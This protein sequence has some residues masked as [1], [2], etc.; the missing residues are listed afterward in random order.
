MANKVG[1]LIKEARTEAGYTQEQLAR[2][3]KD[4]SAADISKA[5]RGELKLS[6]EALK[7]IAKATGVTQK[8]LLDAASSSSYKST[9]TKSTTKSASKSSSSTA[10]SKTSM[11]VSA[12]EK[13]LVELYREADSDTK[14][15]AVALLK[16]QAA[17]FMGDFM[18]QLSENGLPDP[19]MGD[20][21]RRPEG[22]GPEGYPGGPGPKDFP[23]RQNN[24]SESG[25]GQILGG[26]KNLF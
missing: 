5:E 6:Q 7:Q 8:S 4:V 16:G 19:F 15:Q 24:D 26:L 22:P 1:K 25:L 9:S 2:K 20:D 3:V 23:G 10:A 17:D 21:R 18:D 12:A 11:K 14:K 13:K